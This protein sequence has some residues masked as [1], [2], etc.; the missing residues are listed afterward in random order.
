M[1]CKCPEKACVFCDHCTDVFWD[2]TNGPYMVFCDI[3]ADTEKGFVG[4]CELFE[5]TKDGTN[6]RIPEDLRN[7][8]HPFAE[9]VEEALWGK[10]TEDAD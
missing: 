6:K 7:D 10:K 1:R 5:E 3:S 8:C 9:L 4:H 2:Y